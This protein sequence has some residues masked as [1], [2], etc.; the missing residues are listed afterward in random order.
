MVESHGLTVTRTME[1]FEESTIAMTATAMVGSQQ[2]T[3]VLLA[4][5]QAAVT[6]GPAATST[7]LQYMFFLQCRTRKVLGCQRNFTKYI[8]FEARLPVAVAALTLSC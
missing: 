8:N 1:D 6:Q 4:Q 3:D 7:C 2:G 5:Q